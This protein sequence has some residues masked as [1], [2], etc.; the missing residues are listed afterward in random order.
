MVS[1]AHSGSAAHKATQCVRAMNGHVDVAF[2]GALVVQHNN[3]DGIIPLD[4][5][6][7][8]VEV[9]IL[10]GIIEG[11]HGFGPHLHAALFLFGEFANQIVGKHQ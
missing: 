9:G 5:G 7:H 10:V 8:E 4:D 2:D 6:E 11:A 3:G 1:I